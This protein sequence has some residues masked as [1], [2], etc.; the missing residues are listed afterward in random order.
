MIVDRAAVENSISMNS[1]GLYIVAKSALL[2][3][4]SDLMSSVTWSSHGH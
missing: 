1:L 3:L 4:E 2:L